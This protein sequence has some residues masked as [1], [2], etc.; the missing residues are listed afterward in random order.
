MVDYGY[1]NSVPAWLETLKRG[2]YTLNEVCEITKKKYNSVYKR[3]RHLNVK[4]SLTIKNGKQ[5]I[6][7]DWMGKE[8]YKENK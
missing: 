6:K 4:V 8:F 1:S 5:I 3:F 7:Y 2:K